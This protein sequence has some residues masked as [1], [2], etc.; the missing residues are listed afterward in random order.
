MEYYLRSKR[1]TFSKLLLF[2]LI[3]LCT[4]GGLNAQNI[5]VTGFVMDEAG[6][7]VNRATVMVKGANSGTSSDS[8]GHFILQVPGNKAFLFFQ[9]LVLPIRKKQ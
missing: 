4:F 5:R 3:A 7:P 2:T 8:S 1:R 6:K 9:L